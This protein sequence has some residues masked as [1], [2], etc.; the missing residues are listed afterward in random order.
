L[1]G[2]T[3]A[4]RKRSS[5]FRGVTKHRRS[6]RY[7]AHVWVR[8]TGKQV[9]LGGCVRRCVGD[10]ASDVARVQVCARGVRRRSI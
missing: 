2:Q 1:T 5:R 8:E 9:Y 6:G 4:G 3:E 10:A 7:E